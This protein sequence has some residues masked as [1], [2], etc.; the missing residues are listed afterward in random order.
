[1]TKTKNDYLCCFSIA[2]L[3]NL[4]SFSV[5]FIVRF[6]EAASIGFQSLFLTAW[7]NWSICS[8]SFCSA[9]LKRFSAASSESTVSRASSGHISTH[10]GLSSQRLHAMAFPV[11]V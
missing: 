5:I 10:W 7:F 2:F 1:M 9:S 6:S 8:G 3:F 4:S 11:P